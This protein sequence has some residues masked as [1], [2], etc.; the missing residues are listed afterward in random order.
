MKGNGSEMGLKS[1]TVLALICRYLLGMPDTHLG[2]PIAKC[3]FFFLSIKATNFPVAHGNTLHI[4]YG[5]EKS[6]NSF[7]KKKTLLG[8]NIQDLVN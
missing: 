2:D 4:E 7:V 8:E 3:F 1:M 6:G 5:N